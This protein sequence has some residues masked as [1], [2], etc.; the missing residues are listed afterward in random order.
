MSAWVE[1]DGE[2]CPLPLGARYE[3][4]ARDGTVM[5]MLV[6]EDDHRA[7]VWHNGEF[8]NA[9]AWPWAVNGRPFHQSFHDILRFRVIDPH[10]EQRQAMFE[11]LLDVK[12][13]EFEPA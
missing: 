2:I 9:S 3:A 5:V 13:P 10:R 6:D 12:A 1:H 7:E 11:R 8:M 4:V